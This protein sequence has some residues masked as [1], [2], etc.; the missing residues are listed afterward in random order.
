MPF[1][2]EGTEW[3]DSNPVVGMSPLYSAVLENGYLCLRVRL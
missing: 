2:V 1:A 3:V